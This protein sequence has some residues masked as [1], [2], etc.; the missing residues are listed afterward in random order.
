MNRIAPWVELIVTSLIE[1]PQCV[2]VFFFFLAHWKSITVWLPVFFKISYFVFHRRR[3]VIQV[4]N[5][6]R[7]R[8]FLGEPCLQSLSKYWN[9]PKYCI[10]FYN[11][12][13]SVGYRDTFLFFLPLSWLMFLLRHCWNIN[14]HADSPQKAWVC[15]QTWMEDGLEHLFKFAWICGETLSWRCE[16]PQSGSAVSSVTLLTNSYSLRHC[17]TIL[18]SFTKSCIVQNLYDFL[19]WKHKKN[20]LKKYPYN[21][22]QW[23]KTVQTF[24]KVSYLCPT[25]ETKPYWLVFLH[26]QTL[27]KLCAVLSISRSWHE[28]LFQ[29]L[30]ALMSMNHDVAA[31]SEDLRSFYRARIICQC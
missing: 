21:K 29:F 17:W 22:S 1:M 13:D 20:I 5:D 28:K 4:W 16:A 15:C 27:H 31:L 12:T 25:E 14:M 7:G 8:I 9:N 24:F 23:T 2:C 18:P 6:M 3:K 26:V 10:L 19:R 30:L 11:K